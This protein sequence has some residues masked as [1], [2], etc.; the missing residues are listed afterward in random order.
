VKSGYERPGYN[1][2]LCPAEVVLTRMSVKNGR[3]TLPDG[4]GYRMLVLPQV[5]TMTPKLLRKI[6]DLVK[7]GATI[8]G[9]PPKKSPS[10]QGY[11]KCDEEVKELAREL[12]GGFGVPASAGAASEPPKGGTPNPGRSFGRGRVIWPREFQPKPDAAYDSVSTFGS[13]K[14]IWFP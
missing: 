12:W 2:D 3:L 8:I 4:M 6:R 1:F 14:W 7:A 11:P 9:A 13:A 10:L 5:E